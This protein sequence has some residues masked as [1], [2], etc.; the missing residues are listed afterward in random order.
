[1]LTTEGVNMKQHLRNFGALGLTSILA[2][3]ALVPAQS[4]AAASTA[5][6]CSEP[7]LSQPF[8]GDSRW[9]T[10]APGETSGNFDGTGWTLSGG[11]KIV[12]ETLPTGS[13][14]SVLDLPAGSSATSPA[15]CVDG[16]YPLARMET[17]TLGEKPD[18]ST[19]F[20]T[21]PVGS[22]AFSGG[23]PV[24]GKPSWAISP[25]DNVAGSGAAPEQVQFKFVAGKK[26]ADLQVFNLYIDPSMRH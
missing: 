17:R 6:H 18:N 11:A 3:L 19:T 23:M 2:A 7:F 21:V 5:A 24:L 16:T 22:S 1:V 20:Y 12:T 15:M 26:A 25:P 8:A 10:L 14:T 13:T 4:A 9:Y